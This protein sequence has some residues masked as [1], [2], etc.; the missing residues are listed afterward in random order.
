MVTEVQDLRACAIAAETGRLKVSAKTLADLSLH[1]A[2]GCGWSQCAAATSLWLTNFSCNVCCLD[3]KP[4]TSFW[5]V[6]RFIGVNILVCTSGAA[7][8][9]MLWTE[10]RCNT[11]QHHQAKHVM[12]A[13]LA[14]C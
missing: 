11:V 8:K 9:A 4:Q 12:L 2:M 13:H 10:H 3:S 14:V 1:S 6:L 5:L 7:S